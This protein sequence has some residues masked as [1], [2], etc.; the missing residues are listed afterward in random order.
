[1]TTDN[2]T[3]NGFFCPNKILMGTKTSKAKR[4]QPPK[5]DSVVAQGFFDWLAP[6]YDR[7]QPALDPTHF[8]SQAALLDIISAIDPPPEL[9]LDLGIGTGSM[10]LQVLELLPDAHLI[11]IDNSLPMLESARLNLVDFTDRI[12]LAKADFREDWEQIVDVP[13]DAVVQYSSLQ[14]LPHHAVRE[15]FSR[16]VSVLKPGGWFIHGDCINQQ[17]PEPVRRISEEIRRLQLD[18]ARLDL[19][20]DE[21][22]LDELEEIR[23]TSKAKGILNVNP[24]MA[25]QQIAWLIDA[26]FEFAVKVYQDWQVSLFIART[27]VNR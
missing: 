2:D 18:S 7:L 9:V 15:L 13:I 12:T 20:D 4:K 26:G 14:Y 5:K 16:L 10:A 11:G 27:P 25:E 1:M 23:K 17:L 21:E 22:L 8:Q 19:G 3:I 24:A 6:H